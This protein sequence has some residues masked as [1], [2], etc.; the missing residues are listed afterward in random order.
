MSS[1]GEVTNTATSAKN[2]IS[3]SWDE[4]VES[5]VRERK[6]DSGSI[7]LLGFF[8]QIVT[9]F[10]V[11]LLF[12]IIFSTFVL[13]IDLFTPFILMP[14]AWYAYPM[15]IGAAVSL[16]FITGHDKWLRPEEEHQKNSDD[17]ED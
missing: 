17:A 2:T 13:V 11:Y 8:R 14:N 12:G 7:R 1:D 9:E 5:I 10:I 15:Y 4:W 3:S 6:S 16:L